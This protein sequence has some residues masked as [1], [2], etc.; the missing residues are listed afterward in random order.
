LREVETCHGDTESV[1]AGK[2]SR[3]CWSDELPAAFLVLPGLAKPWNTKS[4][5]VTA[6]GLL[7]TRPLTTVAL[8]K[9]STQK[10]CS[11]SA[12]DAIAIIEERANCKMRNA[13]A[14][15]CTRAERLPAMLL[16]T[17]TSRKSVTTVGTY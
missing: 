14:T 2:L 1:V 6:A 11:G 17:T 16:R 8:A 3:K 10:S 12:S 7:H 4:L 13:T 15:R 9:S 5:A